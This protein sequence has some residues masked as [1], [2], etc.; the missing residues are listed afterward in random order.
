M[1]FLFLLFIIFSGCQE[2][3]DETVEIISDDKPVELPIDEQTG[4]VVDEGLNLVKANCL[5]CHSSKIILQNKATKEG[6]ESII[7]WMQETQ[8][9][10]DLGDNKEKIVAYLAKNYGPD[11]TGRR[12]PL[13]NIEWYDLKE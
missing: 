12:K 8:N 2:S 4:F 13:E 6:W 10:W 3:K 5:P 11:E 1:R 7:K 9:L